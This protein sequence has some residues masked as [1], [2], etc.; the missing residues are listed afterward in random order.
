MKT[1]S[2]FWGGRNIRVDVSMWNL[3]FSLLQHGYKTRA[4][5]CG[6]GKYPMTVVYEQDGQPYE[7]FS[8]KIILRKRNF[9]YKDKQGIFHLPE[10]PK[11]DGNIK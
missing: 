8:G 3:V 5:C 1:R 4:C 7:L 11:I 2:V 9:Y 10:V 6:H